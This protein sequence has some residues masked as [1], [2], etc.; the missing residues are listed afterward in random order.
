MFTCISPNTSDVHL[1]HQ[2]KQCKLVPVQTHILINQVCDELWRFDLKHKHNTILTL[3]YTDTLKCETK[4]H[5]HTLK[6]KPWLD[7]SQAVPFQ[8]SHTIFSLEVWS[9]MLWQNHKLARE[10]SSSLAAWLCA[11]CVLC[12]VHRVWCYLHVVRIA[13]GVEDAT[14]W[15]FCQS[16]LATPQHFIK[17]CQQKRKDLSESFCQICASMRLSW[18]NACGH[19]ELKQAL[20]CICIAINFT[21]KAL[22]S[23]THG[24]RSP[25]FGFQEELRVWLNKEFAGLSCPWWG[26]SVQHPS[27]VSLR[28]YSSV[29]LRP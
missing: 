14:S 27:S 25:S 8:S 5:T 21:G 10:Y 13:Q 12:W 20:K 6:K 3:I 16:A 28:P 9:V 11:Q 22:K 29:Q 24:Q 19:S 18:K 2:Y 7:L 26:S 15:F 4:K 1:S 23:L 17:I